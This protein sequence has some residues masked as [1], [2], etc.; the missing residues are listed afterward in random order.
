MHCCGLML[1]DFAVVVRSEREN[2]VVRLPRKAK[3]TGA[4]TLFHTATVA[5][6]RDLSLKK[7]TCIPSF[8]DVCYIYMRQR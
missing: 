4:G 3:N 1:G 7:M 8:H 5:C 6:F 2:T